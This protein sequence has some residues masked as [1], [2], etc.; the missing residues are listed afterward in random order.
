MN[1]TVEKLKSYLRKESP[2]ILSCVGAVGVVAT[3]VLAIKAT[4]KAMDI[5]KEAESECEID[6]ELTVVEKIRLV[7]PVYIPTVIVG[8]CTVGCIIGA[9]VLNQKQQLSLM[10]AYALVDSSF[11]NYRGKL[12]ELCDKDTDI[13][14]L[15]ELSKDRFHENPVHPSDGK[16]LWYEPYRDEFFEMTE[17]EVI[18]AEYS[19]NRNFVLRGESNLNEFYSFLGL[20][21]TDAGSVIGW[22]IYGR[23][24]LSENLWI[25]F[26]HHL[27]V[28]DDGTEY[29]QIEFEFP[30]RIGVIED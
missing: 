24:P 13:C 14:V 25:D 28:A 1:V 3:T 18:E 10:S 15:N 2:V 26:E 7:G 30:S 29:Y 4:P 22:D 21:L 11:K 9:N 23:D 8:A 12:K 6:E 27:V 19:T 16:L 17:K 5:L 20:E